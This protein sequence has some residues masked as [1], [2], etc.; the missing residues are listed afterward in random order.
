LIRNEKPIVL[1][2]RNCHV[3]EKSEAIVCARRCRSSRL[4]GWWIQ[5]RT[6]G[7]KMEGRGG[8]GEAQGVAPPPQKKKSFSG[9]RIRRKFFSSGNENDSQTISPGSFSCSTKTLMP[10]TEGSTA[11]SEKWELHF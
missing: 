9:T 5:K 4:T 6:R 7:G 1:F 8:G 10:S 2:E 3:T 11:E